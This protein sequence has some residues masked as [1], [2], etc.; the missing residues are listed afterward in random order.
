MRRVKTDKQDAITICNYGHDYW[1]QLKDYEAIGAIYEE[2]KLLGRQYRSYM[3][4]HIESVQNL[5]HLLDCVMPRIKPLLG[6]WN[7]SSGKNKLADFAN[8]YWHYDNITK[9]S[10]KQ[11]IASYKNGQKRMD[12]TRTKTKQ[13]KSIVWQKAVPQR[14]SQAIQQRKCWCR[15]RSEC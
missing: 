8:E 12:T 13:L 2:L 10:E 9:K 7:E 3:K 15:N 4:M 14:F 5:T 6:G 1:Y 11:F